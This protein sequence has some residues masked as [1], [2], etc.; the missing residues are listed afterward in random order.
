MGNGSDPAPSRLHESWAGL[1]RGTTVT[2]RTGRARPGLPTGITPGELATLS[3]SAVRK[4]VIRKRIRE[5]FALTPVRNLFIPEVL[6]CLLTYSLPYTA[7]FMI[8]STTSQIYQQEYG[9][10]LMEAGLV[11]LAIGSGSA[12]SSFISGQLLNRNFQAVQAR[13]RA[14]Q[15]KA[16]VATRPSSSSSSSLSP[17]QAARSKNWPKGYD[18]AH[19]P[20]EQARLRLYP[21]AIG[22]N[23]AAT[24]VYGWLIDA[25][26]HPAAP[27][28]FLFLIGLGVG[29]VSNIINTLLLDYLP[30][31]GAG[32]TASLNLVRC[33]LGAAGVAASERMLARLGPGR[34]FTIVAAISACSI[35]CAAG[36]WLKGAACRAKRFAQ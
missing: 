4:R 35:P 19:F 27:I 24:L 32:A 17:S 1:I 20:I 30:G 13:F 15:A 9:W 3:R 25:H 2:Q 36:M 14:A 26:V 7:Q 5:T 28:P 22:I 18:P 23:I 10:T 29:T 34:A 21:L 33:L 12:S 6:M 11:F 8:L 31:K 16:E